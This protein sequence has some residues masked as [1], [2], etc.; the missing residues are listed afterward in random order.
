VHFDQ[1]GAR[2]AGAG[3]W[4]HSASTRLLTLFTVHRR[5]G[6]EAMDAAGVLPGF[7]GTAVH[8]CWACY[9]TYRQAT[10]ALCGAHLLR[11]LAWV[12]EFGGAGQDWAGQIAGLLSTANGWVKQARADGG[13]TLAGWQLASLHARWDGHV[14]QGLAANPRGP[15]AARPP[16]ARPAR[17]STGSRPAATTTCGSPPTSPSPSTTT[18]RSVTS[19]WSSCSRRSLAAGGL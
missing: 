15:A 10:H 13:D 9:D 16:A 14:A 17:S 11:E 19:A 5:R 18:R 3:H 1:T 8:D 6:V 2:V 4:V 12:T 7:T